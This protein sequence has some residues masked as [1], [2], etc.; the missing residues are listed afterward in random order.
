MNK[1]LVLTAILF[2]AFGILAAHYVSAP[3]V[4]SLKNTEQIAEKHTTTVP[5]D[6]DYSDSA[7]QSEAEVAKIVFNNQSAIKLVKDK[8]LWVFR[9]VKGDLLGLGEENIVLWGSGAGCGS[10]HVK[11]VYVLSKDK[12]IFEK[13]VG[14]PIVTIEKDK[15]GKDVLAIVEPLRREDE[16]LCCPSVGVKTLYRWWTYSNTFVPHDSRPYE[17][18][19]E[20]K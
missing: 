5:C 3:K 7:A 19:V 13:W 9:A 8:C 4:S 18:K 1:K 6:Y 16:G 14:D 2:F 12:V 17:Y 20:K 15:N 11:G 10:C